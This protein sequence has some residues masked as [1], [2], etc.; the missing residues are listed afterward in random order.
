MNTGTRS[1]LKRLLGKARPPTVCGGDGSPRRT[2]IARAGLGREA[3]RQTSRRSPPRDREARA[4]LCFAADSRPLRAT[5]VGL[6][7]TRLRY[8]S[9]TRIAQF[10]ASIVGHSFISTRTRKGEPAAPPLSQSPRRGTSLVVIAPMLRTSFWSPVASERM[11]VC[12]GKQVDF[13]R[14]SES[15]CTLI[16]RR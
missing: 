9:A 5:L 8:R 11:R 13:D 4:R 10:R 1:S 7:P 3:L 16:R 14:A 15:R 12:L 6:V 2:R